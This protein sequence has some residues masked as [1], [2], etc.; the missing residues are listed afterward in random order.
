M[1]TVDG[2]ECSCSC[3]LADPAERYYSNIVTSRKS[4]KCCECGEPIPPGQRHELATLVWGSWP[5]RRV[6]LV[7]R[8][9]LPCYGIRRDY[10]CGIYE[11][12]QEQFYECF[13]FHY[14]EIPVREDDDER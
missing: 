5:G 13:G 2:M 10:G 11:G 12:L 3:D 6:S 1:K 4:H 14:T 9:C 8:T 7:F